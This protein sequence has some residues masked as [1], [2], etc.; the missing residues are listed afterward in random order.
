M[1]VKVL[2]KR[3]LLILLLLLGVANAY[4]QSRL[5]LVGV[6]TTARQELKK[7]KTQKLYPNANSVTKELQGLLLF[8]YGRGYL[9]ASIDSLSG[10]SLNKTAYLTAGK[11][12][13]L[14][15]L[16]ATNTD[17][18]LMAKAGFKERLYSNQVFSFTEITQIQ[19]DIVTYAEN[20]GYPFAKVFLDSVV[21][22][23]TN[24]SAKLTLDK[25]Q[26]YKID[27]IV[28]KG[29]ARLGKT[30]LY[31]YIGVKPGDLYNEEAMRRL[32]ARMRELPFVK[33]IKPAELF[34]KDKKV[35]LVLYLDDRKASTFNGVLGFL[36]NSNATQNR[37]IITGEL[38]L[39]LLNALNRA[40]LFDINFRRLQISTQFLDVKAS[41]PYLLNIPLGL[42]GS[43]NLYR[44][45]STFLSIIQNFGV[46]YLMAG[47]NYLKAYVENRGS[48]LLSTTG[49]ENATVLPPNADVSTLQY[50]LELRVDKLDYRFNPRKGLSIFAKAGIGN[51][52]IRQNP[53]INP[54]VYEGLALR[55]TQLNTE[56]QLAYYIPLAKRHVIKTG[57]MGAYLYNPTAFN[58]ELYRL[59]GINSLRGYTDEAL[60][61]SG[62]GIFTLEYR[63]LLEQN[64]YLFAFTDGGYY[65]R[66][67]IQGFTSKRPL[68]FGS[69]VA[70][71]TKVG[72][73]SLV[74]AIGNE[75]NNTVQFRNGKIHFGI[76]SYFKWFWYLLCSLYLIWKK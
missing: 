34:F 33:E 24:I 38:H 36:P 13:R 19:K 29:S 59:G 60:F 39:R 76:T 40:E 67:I 26:L 45:D 30:Y 32:N 9:A 4:A 54:Q 15:K 49:F 16:A 10:D 63:F 35:K 65:E 68:G 27:S 2:L 18:V 3:L 61:V 37:P 69:G 72:I 71:E 43:I 23:K 11:K 5:Q 20:N 64:S 6:D 62:F 28:V 55:T 14:L 31:N 42:D 51:K 12:Y 75:L 70:F 50:G 57:F 56:V 52:N 21:I 25:G 22:D 8:L 66:R 1:G 47:G 41:Y 53:N 74:Y 58:N 48:R 7:Y 17:A 73:F 44:R 46:Q